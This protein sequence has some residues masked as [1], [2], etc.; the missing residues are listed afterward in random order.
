VDR[1]DVKIP[2]YWDKE[3]LIGYGMLG[4]LEALERFQSDKG[5]HL[6]PLLPNASA[7]PLLM[8]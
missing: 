6:Q 8:R 5:A 2:A 3:N 4:L 7:V 1:L